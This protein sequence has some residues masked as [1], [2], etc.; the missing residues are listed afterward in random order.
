MIINYLFDNASAS[1]ELIGYSVGWFILGIIWLVMGLYH[2]LLI[3]PAFGLIYIVVAKIFIWDVAS[4]SS[5]IR[6][7]ALFCLA[8]CM[9]G[10]SWLYSKLYKVSE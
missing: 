7:L 2:K 9:L 8:G 1:T 5:L 6:I 10:L 3:K 4:A